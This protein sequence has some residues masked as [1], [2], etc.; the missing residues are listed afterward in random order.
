MM[1]KSGSVAGKTI[2]RTIVSGLLTTGC[3]IGLSVM[4]GSKQLSRIPV[5]SELLVDSAHAEVSEQGTFGGCD[6]QL[7]DGVLTISKSRRGDGELGSGRDSPW[8]YM[9]KLR[10]RVKT[11]QINPNVVA[12]P[13]SAGLFEAFYNLVEID[14]LENLDVSHVIDMGW[15]FAQNPQLAKLDL[16]S[17]KTSGVRGMNGMFQ[18]N[19]ELTEI[20]G[21]ENFDTDDAETLSGIFGGCEKL[22]IGKL[23]WHTA[24]V[25]DMSYMFNETHN[26]INLDLSSF[27]TSNVTDMERM[28]GRM[29]SLQTLDI[30][31]FNTTMV[32]NMHEMF[33]E[34]VNL[35]LISMGEKTS[36]SADAKLPAVPGDDRLIP[37][38]FN[39][40][41]S[42]SHWVPVETATVHKPAGEK[43][44]LSSGALM[45]ERPEIAETYVW[46]QRPVTNQSSLEIKPSITLDHGADW[47][48]KDAFVGLTDAWGDPLEFDDLN[49]T[50][51]K[52]NTSEAGKYTVTYS[53]EDLSKD[54]VVTVKPK[55]SGGSGESGNNNGNNQGNNNGNQGNNNSNGGLGTS[56]PP[57]ITS[58]DNGSGSTS[59]NQ[60][61][62][63]TNLPGTPQANEASKVPYRVYAR[64]TI[65]LHRNV[66]LTNPVKSYKKLPRHKAHSFEIL[67]VAYSQSGAKRYRVK[68]G[69]ITANKKLVVNQYYQSKPAR[70]KVI[71]P[72]GLHQYLKANLTGKIRHVKKG[73]VLKVKKV[74][75][76]DKA[77]RLQLSNGSYITGN[78]RFMVSY[79]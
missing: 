19:T 1:K 43:N 4:D 66:E 65:R 27:N 57:S 9:P 36:L 50:G 20:K 45:S 37:G 52:V 30:S 62:S 69:Y 77:T 39:Y 7:E 51:D 63:G 16:T 18:A 61:D 3:L 34:D 26:I 8:H 60:P 67:G 79:K 68:G 23:Q 73:H 38:K 29:G 64:R 76:S 5:V 58:P 41:N 35:W 56:T 75:K 2:R 11:I 59:E 72:K 44:R 28:F 49:V 33:D 40:L 14:G 15:I 12:N 32:S 31:S 54:C 53:H 10:D 55:E 13:D 42:S 17:W 22:K 21:I 48:E 24:N 46:Q 6:W 25:N 71:H 70:V 78:K 74:I 47:N